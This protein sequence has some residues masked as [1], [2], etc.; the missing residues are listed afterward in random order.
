M[1]Q[2]CSWLARRVRGRRH[3]QF[4]RQVLRVRVSNAIASELWLFFNGGGPALSIP[5]KCENFEDV[6]D[7]AFH[8]DSFELYT[9]SP[10]HLVKKWSDPFAQQTGV[11]IVDITDGDAGKIAEDLAA[12]TVQ[13][14]WREHRR[15]R[16]RAAAV[17]LQNRVARRV[18]RRRVA[19]GRVIKRELLRPW[20]AKRRAI[21]VV[22]QKIV[23]GWLQRRKFTC[24]ICYET[25]ARACFTNMCRANARPNMPNPT[26]SKH[27]EVCR[28]CARRYI[29]VQVDD[30]KICFTCP[31]SGGIIT[32]EDIDRVCGPAAGLKFL[33][34][35]NIMHSKRLLAL[36]A[37]AEDHSFT[38]WCEQHTRACP[39]C[40][41]IIFRYAGCDH[42]ACRCGYS[43]NWSTAPR[44]G[45]GA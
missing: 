25:L 15:L 39:G 22:L 32:K 10:V 33:E 11:L 3:P 21:H 29:N 31:L 1:G 38:R 4:Q 12:A 7:L 30:G 6:V 35:R 14:H 2:A 28:S 16:R 5:P 45:M 24:P 37:G 26:N 34:N 17:V 44:V 19:A 43:F 23:R 20:L 13:S 36:N 8:P 40:Y 41:V 27:C 42:M 9:K 18:Y